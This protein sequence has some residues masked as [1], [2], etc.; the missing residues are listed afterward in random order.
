MKRL[1]LPLLLLLALSA[2]SSSEDDPPPDPG[3]SPPSTWIG[4]QPGDAVNLT[5]DAGQLTLIYVDE[6]YVVDGTNV[7]ALTF[8]HDDTYVTDYFTEHEGVLYWYGRRGEWRAGRDGETARQVAVEGD[9]V[10]FGDIAITLADDG[11]PTQVETPDG[12]FTA[13]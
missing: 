6:S 12:V 7:S 4:L 3:A 5:G 9:V 2:C 13:D 10:H 8:E 11:P 1:L